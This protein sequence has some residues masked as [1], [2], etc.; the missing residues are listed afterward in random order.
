LA[1]SR[2]LRSTDNRD[3]IQIYLLEQVVKRFAMEGI[4]IS[5]PQTMAVL[6]DDRHFNRPPEKSSAGVNT[7]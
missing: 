4:R 5:I 6:K 2:T 1:R 7:P 3:H